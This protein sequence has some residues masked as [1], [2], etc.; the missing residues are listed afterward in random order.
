[1]RAVRLE[2][3]AAHP[4][5]YLSSLADAEAREDA[6]WRA[7]I[8]DPGNAI[9][10]LFDGEAMIGLG[11]VFT[12]RGDPSVAILAMSYIAPAYR[13]RGLTDL[14]Y[15][16]RLAWA[17]ERGFARIITG[18]RASNTASKHAI[19]RH[20]FRR[21]CARPNNWPDGSI[22]DDIEYELMLGAEP[23]SSGADQGEIS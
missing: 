23:L 2:A 15:R 22:E 5:N 19:L 16:A 7:L 8:E 6:E 3:L 11:S 18:H 12:D 21:T 9:F 20:G 14:T 1:M 10:G 17:R 13:G 4:G